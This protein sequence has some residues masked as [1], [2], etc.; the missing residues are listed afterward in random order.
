MPGV[1]I[2]AWMIRGV[3][4]YEVYRCIVHLFS[5]LLQGTMSY[6]RKNDLKRVPRY[7]VVCDAYKKHS[8]CKLVALKKKYGVDAM[9]Q[10]EEKDFSE[11]HKRFTSLLGKNNENIPYEKICKFIRENNNLFPSL[12]I[13]CRDTS[14]F[15]IA[16]PYL[17][18]SAEIF[19]SRKSFSE[20][21]LISAMRHYSECSIRDG[22]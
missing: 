10:Y 7:I 15:N 1:Q 9:E 4:I 14:S 22:K 12:V 6:T 3:V 18:Y 8:A 13:L 16:S 11:E 2:S 17:L 21:T 20:D 19:H 5:V